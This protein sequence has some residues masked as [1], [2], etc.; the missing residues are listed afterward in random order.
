MNSSEASDNQKHRAAEQAIKS[1]DVLHN[2]MSNLQEKE[3]EKYDIYLSDGTYITSIIGM[4]SLIKYLG[5]DESTIRSGINRGGL[6]KGMYVRT[7]AIKESMEKSHIHDGC[8]FDRK[9]Y[10]AREFKLLFPHGLDGDDDMLDDLEVPR[11]T[12]QPR[13]N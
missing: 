2:L 10:I 6:I 13:Y 3:N 1:L 9:R 11:P 4:S 12:R 8:P 7:K 5:V